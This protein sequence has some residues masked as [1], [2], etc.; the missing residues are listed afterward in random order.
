MVPER[1]DARYATPMPQ[2]VPTDD[3]WGQHGALP[4]DTTSFLGRR[5]EI[6]ELREL[7]ANCRLIT[8]SGSGGVGKTRL[9]LRAARELRR[10]F[11]DKVAFVELA[12]LR[13]AKP[14][15]G[16][17]AARLGLHEQSPRTAIDAIVEHIR[18]SP[19]LLVL[20][21][22]EHLAG[23]TASLVDVL[24]RRCPQ[25]RV[26]ATS[27]HSLGLL[28]EQT[29]VVP[30]LPTPAPGT[31]FS[32]E[33]LHR[34]DSVRLFAE[35]AAAVVPRFEIT[36]DNCDLVARICHDLD[37]I[38][39]AIEL[40][41]G[42]LRALS[43]NQ[44]AQ[45]L[46]ARYQLLSKG[47]LDAPQR[48]RTLR[49]A[50]DWSFDLATRAEQLIWMRASVFSGE[51]DLE[52]VEFVGSCPEIP[53]PDVIEVVE[54]LVAKSILLREDH[55]GQLRYRMLATLREY[56][57]EKLVQVSG[58]YAVRRRHRDFYASLA[59][60]FARAA[61][62]T[63]QVKW[64][65]RLRLDH[66]NL[67]TALEF[68]SSVPGEGSTGMRMATQLDD[69]WT[70]RG[71]HTEARHW[72]DSMLSATGDQHPER[73][74]ALRMSGWFALIQGDMSTGTGLLREA[75]ELA[76]VLGCTTE[77]AYVLHAT[78]IAAFFEGDLD[79]AIVR[80]EDALA[81]FHAQQVL[82]GELFSLFCLGLS[83]GL[84][85]ERARGLAVLRECIEVSTELEEVY[86]RSY[87][88]WSISYIEVLHGNLAMAE[89][90]A[91]EA[92]ELLK[93]IENRVVLALTLDVLGWICERREQHQRAAVLFGAAAQM[94][95]HIDGAPEAYVPFQAPRQEYVSRAREAMGGTAF[96]SAFERG[97][98]FTIEEIFRFA[99]ETK[100]PCTGPGVE[101]R[102]PST[103]TRREH[104]IADLVAEG[105]SNKEI[106]TQLCIAVRTAEGHVE[107]ILTKLGFTSRA[108]IASWVHE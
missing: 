9:A 54:S 59:S 18:P 57:E 91:K 7:L 71:F 67:R 107:H 36:T 62:G 74:S 103:L 52:A 89:R 90:T 98:G 15:A 28:S 65:D 39:L 6:G 76:A 41:T 17:V 93:L 83:A 16:T 73:V 100:A 23:E 92:L 49:A 3:D 77:A 45:R 29:L 20:D 10:A 105:L 84:V 81:Q 64:I 96:E 8:L 47:T 21:N 97:A 102:R 50:V 32:P 48:Q 85:G 58:L 14:L 42:R 5:R 1:L 46:T 56:G 104:E 34:Y 94:W 38:P 53:P 25:L 80:F 108:R 11:R 60:E 63:E 75:G 69:Y 37:G 2:T 27:R 22:C 70:L 106:A 99:L 33:D 86:W 78:G 55:S 95:L 82:R 87:A 79:T 30:P 19:M 31:T 88:L 24:L 43:L 66:P 68:C 35:R 26:I 61:N 40:T 4:V 72:L 44:I 12:E 101:K 51:F 13:D